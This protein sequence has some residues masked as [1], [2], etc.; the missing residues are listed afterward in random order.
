MNVIGGIS[1]FLLGMMMM[2][3]GLK[4]ASGD[5]LK[6]MMNRFTNRTISSI[7]TGT[8]I[9]NITQ[10]STATSIMTIGFVNAGILPFAQSIGVIFGANL[11][12]TT[13]AWLVAFLGVKFS[14][15]Q[16]ALPMIAVGVILMLTGKSWLP[17]VGKAVAGFGLLFFGIQLLQNG[18]EALDGYLSFTTVSGVDLAGRLLLVLIGVVMTIIMQSSAASVATTITMLSIGSLQIDQAIALVIGQN[19]GTTA[20]AILAAMGA[21]VQAKRTA[22]AHVLFNL[23]TAFLVFWLCPFILST[24]QAFNRLM[25]W[26]DPGAVVA[27]FHTSFSVLGILLLTPFVK[28]FARLIVRMLPDEDE[29]R[30]NSRSRA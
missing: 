7:V 12:S 14:I 2:A 30:K 17:H 8:V 18:M 4:S 11:G 16:L 29:R 13:T 22:A 23:I 26:E 21:G 27:V 19:I 3:E 1:F 20:T 5:S 9:T 15:S 25:G 28:P 24:I 10:S 6:K